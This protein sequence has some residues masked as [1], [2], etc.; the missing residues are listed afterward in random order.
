MRIYLAS[1][2]RNL[3]Y[4]VILQALRNQG[5]DVYDF[6]NPVEGEHGFLW[7]ELDPDYTQWDAKAY[8]K[9]LDN[10]APKLAYGYNV[11]ALEN[12]QA[13]VLILP[14]G[15]SAHLQL[16]YAVGKKQFTAILLEEGRVEPELMYKMVD[17]ITPSLDIL[18][19]EL[20]YR[21]EVIKTMENEIFA[22]GYGK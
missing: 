13:T 11:N 16:G 22:K 7:K 20:K 21:E 3:K 1:S 12:A 17:C 10:P 14:C 18:V 8:I 15:K 2:W 9:I 6:K 4:P 19:K 5:H